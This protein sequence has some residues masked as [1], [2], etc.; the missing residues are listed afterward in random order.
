MNLVSF[1]LH[2]IQ[3]FGFSTIPSKRLGTS[4]NKGI[5][6]FTVLT[7]GVSCS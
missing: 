7:L 1:L 5:D 6:S 4:P 2:L 3:G